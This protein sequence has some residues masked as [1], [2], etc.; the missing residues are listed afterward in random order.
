MSKTIQQK[1]REALALAQVKDAHKASIDC[2]PVLCH[3]P[4][5][6]PYYHR[7]SN[8]VAWSIGEGDKMRTGF[9]TI[10]ARVTEFVGG[11]QVTL[12]FGGT[13]ESK[14]ETLY[15]AIRWNEFDGIG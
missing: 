3:D 11:N 6:K 10:G 1:A 4:D 15:R 13:W 14:A 5:E 12:P 2:E 7:T 8:A 9:V